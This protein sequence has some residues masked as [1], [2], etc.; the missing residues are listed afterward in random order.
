MTGFPL[1]F[2]LFLFGLSS[3]IAYDFEAE[4]Q[5]I[6]EAY[7]VKCHGPDRQKGRVRF[8]TLSTDF[9]QD[10]AAAETWHDASDQIQLGEMPPDDEPEPTSQER[11]ILTSW[12]DSNLKAAL[13]AKTTS[14]NGIVMRRLN[15][16]E[17]Q[18][19]MADL[20]GLRFDYAAELPADALSPDGFR[21]NGASLGMSALQ[22]ETY[23]ETAREALGLILVEGGRP[24]RSI[25]PLS[26]MEKRGR[27]RLPGVSSD[28]LGRV[29]YWQGGGQS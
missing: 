28:R 4:V 10:S 6:L 25:H 24:E 29:N 3:L 17:Y 27:N 23:L 14:G 20:L 11:E 15:R 8:D 5:P 7:C 12:I 2:T 26:H 21:N 13:S 18:H 9:L 22:M 19:S 16:H 1:G